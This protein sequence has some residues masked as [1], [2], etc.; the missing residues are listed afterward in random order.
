MNLL[1]FEASLI[2]VVPAAG[3]GKRMRSHYP[4]QYLTFLGKTVLE[5]TVER[6]LSHPKITRVILALG[7]NDEYFPSLA[8]A[9]N[10]YVSTVIGGK[11]RVDSVLAGLQYINCSEFSWVLVHDAARP[12][13]SHQD[14]TQLITRCLS[15]GVGGL[16][17]TPVRD[18]MKRS[19]PENTLNKAQNIVQ[20]TEQRDGLWH[21]L[22]PQMYKITELK[23][24]IENALTQQLAITDESSAIELAGLPSQLVEASSD[25][26]KITRPD[27][28]ALAEFILMKQKN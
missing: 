13:V 25:N 27:D 23:N 1:S 11:E 19:H 21:A 6:L 9:N 14:I 24:A 22:T 18:T 16:L 8:L 28:L 2:A 3:I 26:I 10:P 4:K 5:H 17:A 15:T 12:C 7:E 20:C